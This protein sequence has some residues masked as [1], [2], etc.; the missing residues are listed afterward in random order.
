MQERKVDLKWVY[1]KFLLT[2]NIFLP[3]DNQSSNY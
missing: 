1:Q 3:D 2:F